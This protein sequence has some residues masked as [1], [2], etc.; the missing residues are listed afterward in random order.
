MATLLLTFILYLNDITLCSYPSTPLYKKVNSESSV[1]YWYRYQQIFKAEIL[2]CYW[3]QK[4]FR[5]SPCWKQIFSQFN[6][7][8][9]K[10]S[11]N[12]KKKNC[13]HYFLQLKL[14]P[15]LDAGLLGF[16][17]GWC[18]RRLFLQRGWIPLIC[19]QNLEVPT[20]NA[21]LNTNRIQSM[22]YRLSFQSTLS[23]SFARLAPTCWEAT[24]CLPLTNWEKRPLRW[25]WAL[26]HTWQ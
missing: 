21:E 7:T 9:D 18:W 2:V 8:T 12:K 22:S 20:E 11:N 17:F 26:H 15:H 25:E 1:A 13:A 6:T 24:S 16:E 19:W 14:A 3:M 23:P 10:N 5:G 4:E